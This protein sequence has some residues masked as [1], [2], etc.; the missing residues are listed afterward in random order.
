M[1]GLVVGR[2][3][4]SDRLQNAS[5]TLCDF[6]PV[7]LG[8][9]LCRR[10]LILT[11][12]PGIAD[13]KSDRISKGGGIIGQNQVMAAP[14]VQAFG[15]DGCRHQGLSHRHCLKNLQPRPASD[16]KWY[17]HNRSIAQVI[18]DGRNGT[19]DLYGMGCEL[20]HTSVR[21]STDDLKYRRRKLEAHPRKNIPA[22]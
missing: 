16:A 19:G 18:G 5:E 10:Q 17:D 11:T 15:T 13:E 3:Q 12:K 20:P 2:R 6:R 7:V 4:V 22:E 1:A 9:E 21:T 8:C 14:H